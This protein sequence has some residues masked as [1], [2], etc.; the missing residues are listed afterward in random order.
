MHSLDRATGPAAAELRE[1]SGRA[2]PACAAGLREN[3]AAKRKKEKQ[4]FGPNKRTGE[5]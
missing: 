1:E 4:A 5:F 3:W 2:G